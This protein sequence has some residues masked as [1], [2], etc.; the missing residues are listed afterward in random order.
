[1]IS[2]TSSFTPGTAENSC[3][4]PSMWTAGRRNAPGREDEQHTAQAVAQRLAKP[5]LERLDHKACRTCH[6]PR[7]PRVRLLRFHGHYSYPPSLRF[8]VTKGGMRKRA[9][10]IPSSAIPFPCLNGSRARRSGAHFGFEAIDV[11]AGQAAQPR[12]RCRFGASKVSHFGVTTPVPSRSALKAARTRGH[13]SRR[14]IT[15]PT[16]TE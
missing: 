8:G 11:L 14:V 2:A 3:C 9:P 7:L 16:F 1:M 13:V 6:C 12:C 10:C 5:A 15:S 4:T